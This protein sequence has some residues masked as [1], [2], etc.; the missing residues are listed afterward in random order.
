LAPVFFEGVHVVRDPGYNVAS[1]NLTHRRL[2]INDHGEIL[3]NGQPLR[4][5]HFSKLGPLADTMTQ[6]YAK[7]NLEVYEVWSWYRRRINQLKTLGIP[8]GWWH[9]ATFE[10]GVRISKPV[11]VIY[12]QR[13]DLKKAFP[14]PFSVG[15]GGG[16]FGWLKENEPLEL[17]GD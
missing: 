2:V 17:P 1:W 14:N 3:V 6:R 4:F 5:Y 11:R 10:N 16:Y 9:Y 8:D 13:E 15:S 12:R 7:D